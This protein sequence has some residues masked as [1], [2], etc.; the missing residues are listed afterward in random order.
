MNL[1]QKV[2]KIYKKL[3]TALI[4]ILHQKTTTN[5]QTSS[6]D[7]VSLLISHDHTR[8]NCSNIWQ[9]FYYY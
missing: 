6:Y 1:I 5:D 8:K 2:K 9:N 7:F 4:N 3:R